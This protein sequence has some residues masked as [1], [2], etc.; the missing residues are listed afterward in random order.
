MRIST[1]S[2]HPKP[3]TNVSLEVGWVWTTYLKALLLYILPSNACG[4]VISLKEEKWKIE[5]L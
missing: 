2:I 5:D 1:T 3:G 4:D